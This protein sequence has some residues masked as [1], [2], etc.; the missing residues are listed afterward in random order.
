MKTGGSEIQDHRQLYR[1]FEATLSY[2]G[3]YS[4]NI[5]TIR[6]K[7][8]FLIFNFFFFNEA[9]ILHTDFLVNF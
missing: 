7:D 8:F 2:R 3:A 1:V 6:Q 5:S 9:L 4:L